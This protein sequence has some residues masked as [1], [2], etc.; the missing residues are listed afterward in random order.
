MEREDAASIMLG[1]SKFNT[2][3]EE[4]L[5]PERESAA[6]SAQ[7]EKMQKF[8]IPSPERPRR[9]RRPRTEEQKER[10]RLRAREY[11]KKAAALLTKK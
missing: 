5:T 1:L 7:L 11:R 2:P 9:I 8:G 6:I 3:K 10:D 4:G